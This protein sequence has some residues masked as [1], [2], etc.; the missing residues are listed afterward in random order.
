MQLVRPLNLGCRFDSYAAHSL[1]EQTY[2]RF[3]RLNSAGVSY[4][5]SHHFFRKIGRPTRRPR[6]SSH[7]PAHRVA[8]VVGYRPGFSEH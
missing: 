6:A 5:L 3:D 4:Q 2:E 1:S 7:L 8:Q